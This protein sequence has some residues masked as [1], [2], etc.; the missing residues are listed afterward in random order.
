MGKPDKNVQMTSSTGEA[1]L[2]IAKARKIIY[3]DDQNH[4]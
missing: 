3:K 4:R 2:K 1:F